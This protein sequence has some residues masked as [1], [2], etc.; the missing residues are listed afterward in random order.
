VKNEYFTTIILLLLIMTLIVLAYVSW[1][2]DQLIRQLQQEL[3][4]ERQLNR[5]MLAGWYKPTFI[6]SPTSMS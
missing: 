2:G 4:R 6:T 1:K 3:H 5:Q